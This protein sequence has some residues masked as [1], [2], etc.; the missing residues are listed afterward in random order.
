MLELIAQHLRLLQGHLGNLL[1]LES[2]GL[3]RCLRLLVV[4][5]LLGRRG[6]LHLE[7][8]DLL[9]ASL[10]LDLERLELC[11]KILLG[12]PE[13]LLNGAQLHLKARDL[14]HHL[15]RALLQ[16]LR[17]LLLLRELHLDC[18]L[19]LDGLLLALTHLRQRLRLHWCRRG[20]RHLGLSLRSAQERACRRLEV[21]H[22]CLELQHSVSQVRILLLELLH[23]RSDGWRRRLGLGLG[24][25]LGLDG[26]LILSLELSELVLHLG[27]VLLERAYLLAQPLRRSLLVR[28]LL[29][30]SDQRLLRLAQLESECV[31]LG[32]CVPEPHALRVRLRLE[33][34]QIG[35]KHRH[36]DLARG[37]EVHLH[38]EGLPLVDERAQLAYGACHD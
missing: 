8:L 38:S 17:L 16:L 13:L 7:H 5:A 10:Q 20:R 24:L 3:S 30:R 2:S 12:L 36:C 6:E 37:D 18:L 14:R 19:P 34:C 31:G 32:E 11:A 9:L 4:R 25:G 35:D 26:G 23:L 28:N 21:R 27:L 1:L 33:L 15:H 22:A 29:V